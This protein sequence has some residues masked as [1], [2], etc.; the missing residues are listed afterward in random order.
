MKGK[1]FS[2]FVILLVV[3]FS[4]AG[5][6]VAWFTDDTITDVQKFV[7]G[8]LKISDPLLVSETGTWKAGETASLKYRMENLGDQV[9]Y[10]RLLPDAEYIGFAT[11]GN[12]FTLAAAEPEWV[13]NDNIYW[14]YGQTAPVSV[15]PGQ[16]VEATFAVTMATDADGR[17]S[18][19]LEAQAIQSSANSLLKQWLNH[20]W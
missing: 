11:A 14:Y 7:V 16:T 9:V 13:T 8:T 4:M 15:S 10:V 18:F 6:V 3:V 20:P 12:P 2:S 5:G 19:S 1:L 17:V